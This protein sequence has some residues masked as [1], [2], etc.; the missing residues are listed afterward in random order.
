[1]SIVAECIIAKFNSDFFK[2]KIYHNQ[3]KSVIPLGDGTANYREV[4]ICFVEDVPKGIIIDEHVPIFNVLP[5]EVE[6]LYDLGCL[7]ITFKQLKTKLKVKATL[8][9]FKWLVEYIEKLL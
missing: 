2:K 1:M 9:G 8:P 6:A 3:G 4:D 7:P 5:I